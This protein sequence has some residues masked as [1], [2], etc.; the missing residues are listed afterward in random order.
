VDWSVLIPETDSVSRKH[1]HQS[2]EL[3][4]A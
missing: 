1:Y 3:H 2:N 4:V